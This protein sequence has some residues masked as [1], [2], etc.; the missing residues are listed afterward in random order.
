MPG[1]AISS[2]SSPRTPRAFAVN[3]D[4]YS[5]SCHR[6]IDRERDEHDVDPEALGQ[7]PR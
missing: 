1:A 4:P 6:P 5:R 7:R 2:G 3:G